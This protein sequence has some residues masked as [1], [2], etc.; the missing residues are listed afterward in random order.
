M[1]ETQ[2]VRELCLLVTAAGDE[3]PR[4]YRD[5]LGLSGG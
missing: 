5:A 4:C 1:S 3:A 2:A